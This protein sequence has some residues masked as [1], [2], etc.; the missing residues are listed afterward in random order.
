MAACADWFWFPPSFLF[1]VYCLLFFFFARVKLV[2]CEAGH[3]LC[4]PSFG[5]NETVHTVTLL[6]L[7]SCKGTH[8][9]LPVHFKQNMQSLQHYSTL[10]SDLFK[11]TF[12]I[13]SYV[14]HGRF[15]RVPDYSVERARLLVT[16]ACLFSD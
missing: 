9:C 8:L 3:C 12:L 2:Q 5:I 1:K 7:L 10:F 11:I 13:Y 15:I 16:G 6:S 4:L 14:F